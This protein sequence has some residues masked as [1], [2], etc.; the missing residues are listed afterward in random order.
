MPKPPYFSTTTPQSLERSLRDIYRLFDGRLDRL[1][2]GFR[3]EEWNPSYSALS[4]MDWENVTTDYAVYVDL[5]L[6]A[7][8]SISAVGE[9]TGTAS[10]TLYFTLPDFGGLL[11]TQPMSALVSD[12]AT[13]GGFAWASPASDGT[14]RVGVWRYDRSKYTVGTGRRV[15]CAGLLIKDTG[16]YG[17][18]DET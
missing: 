14:N 16:E 8:F 10:N 9:T 4:P 6:L 18:F 17:P 3:L 12:G 15:R 13:L 1:N 7:W 2:F 5:G 11:P